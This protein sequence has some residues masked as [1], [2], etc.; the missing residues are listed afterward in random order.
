MIAAVLSPTV[1]S[2]QEASKA[3]SASKIIGGV[4]QVLDSLA[5]GLT[6]FLTYGSSGEAAR[7][8]IGDHTITYLSGTIS[9][10]AV[11][12][13]VLPNSILLPGVEYSAWVEGDMVEVS[14]TG[15]S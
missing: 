5:P 6:V 10:S 1:Q 3:E 2:V 12:K 7:I 9:V 13:W 11:T 8:F 15:G 4:Q 14:R